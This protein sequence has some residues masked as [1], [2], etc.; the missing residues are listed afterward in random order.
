MQRC[1]DFYV[2]ARQIAPGE[3]LTV[4]EIGSEEFNGA[5]RHIFADERFAYIGCDRAPGPGVD[6][7]LEDPYKLPLPDASADIVVSG[8]MLEHCEFFWLSFGEMLRVLKPDGYL[9]LIA[10]SGGPIHNYPVDCYRFYPDAFRALARYAGCQLLDMWHDDRGPWNDLVGIF[11][12]NGAAS[13]AV[14]DII[15]NLTAAQD[16]VQQRLVSSGMV[17]QTTFNTPP[18][19]DR[20][21]GAASY[22]AT[23]QQLHRTLAPQLYFEIGVRHGRSLALANGPA[24]G[25]DPAPDLQVA[26][27]PGAAIFRETSDR[28]F[29]ADAQKALARGIDVA[30]IDGMHR[31]EYVLRDLMN[32]ERFAR[33]TL[34]AAIDD[35]FPS[36]P[37]QAERD[38]RSRVWCG[39]VWKITY[40]LARHRPDLLVLRLDVEP[41]GLLLVTGFDPGN[42]ALRDNY[43]PIARDL[44]YLAAPELPDEVSNRQGALAPDDPRIADLLALLRELAQSGAAHGMVR[45]RL[46]GWRMQNRL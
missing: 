41:A 14:Q 6:L 24:V 7:V 16:E 30:F 5:Y 15:A 11:R 22:L 18:E 23:L 39:D 32:V 20:T 2:A 38:R 43:N 31:S 42:R 13:P 28:F 9:F 17:G 35:V 10:P 1:Y 44:V 8:Q 40:V 4:V 36:H 25:V 26:P 27:P 45:A 12:H 29:L 3:K 19:A 37:L 33:P 34:I 21:Q 46:Q